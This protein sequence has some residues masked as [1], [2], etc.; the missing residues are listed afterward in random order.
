MKTKYL[1]DKCGNNNY[2]SLTTPLSFKYGSTVTIPCF[3]CKNCHERYAVVPATAA[4]VFEQAVCFII[5]TVLSVL[6]FYEYPSDLSIFEL[7]FVAIALSLIG[8]GILITLWNYIKSYSGALP[9]KFYLIHIDKE[10]NVI[11]YKDNLP[12]YIVTTTVL[13]ERIKHIR[14]N[15]VY[16]I[17]T[18]SDTGAVQLLSYD[19]DDTFLKLKLRNVSMCTKILNG[20]EVTITDSLNKELCRGIIFTE[21]MQ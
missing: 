6:F 7:I 5:P 8:Y 4:I 9:I 15:T 11:Q 1:C 16:I 18:E 20:T 21:E 12:D 14:E 13:S 17:R 3:E 10:Y 19:I 2:K